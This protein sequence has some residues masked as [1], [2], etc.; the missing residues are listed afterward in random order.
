MKDFDDLVKARTPGLA[1]AAAVVA[2]LA[3]TGVW[4]L[5]EQ[6]QAPTVQ[7]VAAARSAGDDSIALQIE[8]GTPCVGAAKVDVARATAMS[9]TPVWAPAK[10]PALA[11]AWTCAGELPAFTYGETTLF[12]EPGWGGIDVKTKFAG[13]A[14]EAGGYVDTIDGAPALIQP[15]TEPGTKPQVLMVRGDTLIR[16]LGVEGGQVDEAT[17]LAESMRPG[18]PPA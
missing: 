6:S 11:A 17:T 14:E 16:L 12:L 2:V 15:A 9:Q 18:A 4:D 7:R 10:G 13:L 1:T 3:S 8:P 5:G